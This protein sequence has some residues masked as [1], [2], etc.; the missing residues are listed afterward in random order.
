MPT[1][2]YCG[3]C[4]GR[5]KQKPRTIDDHRTRYPWQPSSPEHHIDTD[6][7]SEQVETPS[8]SDVEGTRPI[9]DYFQP[10]PSPRFSPAQ[11]ASPAS[12][13]GLEE[14]LGSMRASSPFGDA[15]ATSPSRW[16]DSQAAANDYEGDQPLDVFNE[17]ERE[18][19]FEQLLDRVTYNPRNNL[20]DLG[21]GFD[22]QEGRGDDFDLQDVLYDED[23]G[24][25]EGEV[26]RLDNALSEFQFTPDETSFETRDDSDDE[27]PP[28]TQCAA[29]QEPD[30]IRN[31]YIDAFI[32]KTLYGATHRA[33]KHQLRA[34]RRTIA[35][36]PDIEAE[37]IAKMAQTIGTAERRLGVGT[38]H[39]IKTFTLCPDC[40]RRYSPEYIRD[41][42]I[43]TCINQDCPGV[44]FT[45]RKLASGGQRRVSNLTYPFASPIAWIAHIL[46]L[47][48]MSELM[49][50]WRKTEDDREELAAP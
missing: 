38:D 26:Q 33:L 14:A 11:S 5:V 23:F 9:M 4:Q 2:C 15:P 19:S 10:I 12:A 22:H 40:G 27:D 34:A 7:T 50:T 1:F 16:G 30:L 21:E 13:S 45:I 42:D 28:E 18:Y 41:T 32:Q 29:F 47:P 25:A 37:D 39:I 31:A 8:F 17:A 49:Q 48:G 35:A 43:D 46:S 3:K 20:A 36:H 24:L 44:L 6:P